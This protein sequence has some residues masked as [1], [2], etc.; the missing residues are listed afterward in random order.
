MNPSSCSFAKK[1]SKARAAVSCQPIESMNW[2]IGALSEPIV[3]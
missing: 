2:M 3:V 1:K